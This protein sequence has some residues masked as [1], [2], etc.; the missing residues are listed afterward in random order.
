MSSNSAIFLT[1]VFIEWA[2][3][4]WGKESFFLTAFEYPMN[5]MRKMGWRLSPEFG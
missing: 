2:M 3:E 1:V 5:S 4:R